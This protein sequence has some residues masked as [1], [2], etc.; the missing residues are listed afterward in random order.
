MQRIIPSQYRK[1]EYMKT[2]R[3][4][5]KKSRLQKEDGSILIIGMILLIAL[6]FIGIAA[7][8]TTTTEVG[9]AGNARFQ[10]MAFYQA[11]GGAE[12]AQELLEQNVACPAG[13]TANHAGDALIEGEVVVEGASRA[14]YMNLDAPV[15]SDAIRDIYYPPDYVAGDPH[16]NI[17]A[18][19]QTQYTHGSAMQIAAGYEG[20]GK[21]AAG[22]GASILYDIFSQHRGIAK[23][24][25][26]VTV[27]WK[28]VIIPYREGECRY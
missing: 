6:S 1:S 26:I 12:L 24:E 5:N 18:G 19:G 17:T 27:T 11:E 16:T 9:I 22:G 3:R 7:T 20:I 25:G 4:L 8:K 28:H 10:K 14:F 15:P 21:G 13:F 23:S 2:D